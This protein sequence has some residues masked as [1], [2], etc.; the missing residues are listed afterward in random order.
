GLLNVTYASYRFRLF[1]SESD[2]LKQNF[3]GIGL[4]GAASP[5]WGRFGVLAEVQPLTILRLYAQYEFIGNFGTFDL[6]ASFPSATSDFSDSAIDE[7]TDQEG[8]EAYATTGALLTLG[9]TLQLKVG[10]IAVRSLFRA[11]HTNYDTREGDRV[12]YD[13][14]YDMLMPDD[15]WMVVND[16]DV[17][18]VLEPGSYQLAVGG[19]WTYSHSFYREGDHFDAGE[20]VPNNDIHRV[21][22]I[23]AWTL[24]QDPGARFD[25]PTLILLM[26]WHAKHRWRTGEDVSTALPYIG[27]AFSF[28]GDLLG[29]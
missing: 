29:H 14:I 21:G 7:R 23:V 2:I 4:T 1:E 3:V 24:N 16:L 13:Q 26:Q 11:V 19:R 17:F 18:L 15:G 27:L 10:P 8:T 25:R 6:F 22:P 5:A 20:N 28:Q 12:Y 9:A